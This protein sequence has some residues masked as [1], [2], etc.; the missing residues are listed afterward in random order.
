MIV[1]ASSEDPAMSVR[2]VIR[3]TTSNEMERRRRLS[4]AA[5]K[6]PEEN[7]SEVMGEICL[8]KILF[9]LLYLFEIGLLSV[10]AQD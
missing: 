2:T 10:V 6:G 3:R 1:A 9:V 4:F 5:H 7:R 8:M